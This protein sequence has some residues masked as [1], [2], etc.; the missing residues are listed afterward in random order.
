M[1]K[2]SISRFKLRAKNCTLRLVSAAASLNGSRLEGFG[3]GP[4]RTT[5]G[6]LDVTDQPYYSLVEKEIEVNRKIY[7]LHS[8]TSGE[9]K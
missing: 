1:V 8:G 4:R 7:D 9:S 3:R 2:R 6:L 5:Q